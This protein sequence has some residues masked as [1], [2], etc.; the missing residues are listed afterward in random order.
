[1]RLE[2]K[3]MSEI[4]SEVKLS[5]SKDIRE[6]APFTEIV[7]EK[8]TI[9]NT[10]AILTVEGSKDLR[11]RIP[12]SHVTSLEQ[13]LDLYVP[14]EDIMKVLNYTIPLWLKRLHVEKKGN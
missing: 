8:A 1:M 14:I 13:T 12:N 7:A 5:L 3:Y 4:R 2:V 11:I 9:G 6:L 10:K